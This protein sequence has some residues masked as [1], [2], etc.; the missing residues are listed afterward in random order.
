MV[1]VAQEI[2]RR[3]SPV[4]HGVGL[5]QGTPAAFRTLGIDPLWHACQRR[6]AGIGRL[7]IVYFRQEERQFALWQWDDAAFLA[8]HDRNRL[9]PV[10]LAGKDPVPELIFNNLSAEFFGTF[11]PCFLRSSVIKAIGIY[12]NAF[13][14]PR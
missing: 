9:A 3:A 1:S 6:L 2:P 12:K 10:A 7:I 14:F 13:A 4:G 5:A 8:M 11:L